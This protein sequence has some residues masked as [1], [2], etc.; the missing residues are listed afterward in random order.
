ME[1][2][3]EVF[4]QT[5]AATGGDTITAIRTIRERFGLNPREA[6][7]VMLQ[8]D[9]AADRLDEHQRPFAHLD[10]NSS[11]H[12]TRQWLVGI[13]SSD[14]KNE[15]IRFAHHDDSQLE[16]V[17][18]AMRARCHEVGLESV[19]TH[20]TIHNL[21]LQQTWKFVRRYFEIGYVE[22][23]QKWDDHHSNA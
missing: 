16:S 18:A 12:L 11:R 13:G 23:K 2:P 14:M 7:E 9:G 17:A 21:N 1:S 5:L 20:C 8:S 15:E 3:L 10:S 6:K 4:Q 19:I 22:F